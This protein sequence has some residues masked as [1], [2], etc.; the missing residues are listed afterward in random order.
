[1]RQEKNFL[2]NTKIYIM[3][4][5]VAQSKKAFRNIVA[6]LF[7]ISCIAFHTYAFAGIKEQT[8]EE[9]RAL[10]YAEQ[11]KG[12]YNK[13]LSFYT[14]AT[15]L[16]MENAVLLND[17]GVLF[18]EVDFYRRAESYYL[19]AIQKDVH[20]L[21]PY[22]NL[23]YFYQRFG[24]IEEAKKYF[25]MRFELGDAR[26][27]WAQKAQEE[28]IKLDP[29][30]KEWAMALE[31]D[32]LSAQ[33]ETK[34]YEEF[35]ESV[36]RSQEH[37]HRGE[38]LFKDGDYEEAMKEYNHALY[39]APGSPK[40]IVAQEKTIL[41]ITKESIKNQSELAIRRLEAGDTLSARHEIQKIL[42]TIPEEPILISR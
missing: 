7:F 23:A 2:P 17:M 19:R 34:S 20:Y 41:E 3:L 36:K 4:T 22:M 16:G 14:K 42:T 21:P 12:N 29:N 24:R 30:Y 32:S 39:W 28:L 40:V 27:P 26:D 37:Y 18:E 1:M 38:D 11:Q 13:A 25:K 6:L 15:S 31:A 8:A 10:G 9:Y 33:L 5:L 35:Y